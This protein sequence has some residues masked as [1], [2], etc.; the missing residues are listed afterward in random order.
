[1]FIGHYENLRINGKIEAVGWSWDSVR[2]DDK[3]R[4]EK[5]TPITFSKD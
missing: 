5:F 2:N 4:P 1:M 3:H